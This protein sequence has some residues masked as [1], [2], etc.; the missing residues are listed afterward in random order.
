[1]L[2]CSSSSPASAVYRLQLHVCPELTMAFV[3]SPPYLSMER[4]C[5]CEGINASVLGDT[6]ASVYAELCVNERPIVVEGSQDR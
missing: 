6:D 1:M 2:P 5:S 3:D 4:C